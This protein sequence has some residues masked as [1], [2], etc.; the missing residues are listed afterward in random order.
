MDGAELI[1]RVMI[2]GDALDEGG[3]TPLPPDTTRG[4]PLTLGGGGVADV[5]AL[6]SAPA[7][8]L[9]WNGL[10]VA[11]MCLGNVCKHATNPWSPVESGNAQ[12]GLEN[13]P[14]AQRLRL[15][16]TCGRDLVLPLCRHVF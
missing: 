14:K 3:A 16:P 5:G 1:E 4:G 6:K 8:L 12:L 9:T 13:K 7:F 2:A 10:F 15:P 11:Q